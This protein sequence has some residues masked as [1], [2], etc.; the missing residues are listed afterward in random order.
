[1]FDLKDR[2]KRKAQRKLATISEPDCAAR[3]V[4]PVRQFHKVDESKILPHKRLGL[5]FEN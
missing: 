5:L 3:G 1:M 4:A 2:S